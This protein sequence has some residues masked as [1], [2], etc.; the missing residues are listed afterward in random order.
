[1]LDY[2]EGD[3]FTGTIGYDFFGRSCMCYPVWSSLSFTFIIATIAFDQYSRRDPLAD[4][5][6]QLCAD[7]AKACAHFC[8]AQGS[9][10]ANRVDAHLQKP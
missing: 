10:I 9:Q 5:T 6:A 2:L 7:L 8:L 4:P 3:V 1:M